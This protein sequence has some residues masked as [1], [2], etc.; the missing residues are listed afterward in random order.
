[1]EWLLATCNFMVLT[2]GKV[3]CVPLAFGVSFSSWWTSRRCVGLQDPGFIPTSPPPAHVGY[4]LCEAFLG[5]IRA[6]ERTLA[7]AKNHSQGQCTQSQ[8]Q[9]DLPRHQAAHARACHEP[10]GFQEDTGY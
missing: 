7:A 5:E 6:F 4:M 1:M 10:F 9:P 8:P 2:F 3:S